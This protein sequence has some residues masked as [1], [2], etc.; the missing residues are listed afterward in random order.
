MAVAGASSLTYPGGIRGYGNPLKLAADGYVHDSGREVYTLTSASGGMD[1]YRTDAVLATGYDVNSGPASSN[2]SLLSTLRLG[3]FGLNPALLLTPAN[4]QVL[5]VLYLLQGD[6]LTCALTVKA[7]GGAT[8]TATE[9]T[10]VVSRYSTGELAWTAKD[11]VGVYRALVAPKSN[12]A[13]GSLCS[14]GA[15][16]LLEVKVASGLT[17]V[18]RMVVNSSSHEDLLFFAYPDGNAGALA[19][20][21]WRDTSVAPAPVTSADDA[22]LSAHFPALPASGHLA[23][24]PTAVDGGAALVWLSADS[25]LVRLD[26]G[27]GAVSVTSATY[28]V[29]VLAA[30]G[31]DVGGGLCAALA[32]DSSHATLACTPDISTTALTRVSGAPVLPIRVSYLLVVGPA[33]YSGCYTSAS[34]N[35]G[36][37]ACLYNTS[38]ASWSTSAGSGVTVPYINFATLGG[39]V[40]FTG[41]VGSATPSLYT[42]PPP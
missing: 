18:S 3:K 29:L 5:Q 10:G 14:S 25:R 16:S 40:Y 1:A 32:E 35:A 21:S 31:P 9:P 24:A 34:S 33:L 37:Y 41:A 20:Y 17:V 36:P 11:G 38:S 8:I 23:V 7:A 26:L 15:G 2:P 27:N 19:L 28:A 6:G 4:A 22:L 39:Q 13:S 30:L 42:I 12:F